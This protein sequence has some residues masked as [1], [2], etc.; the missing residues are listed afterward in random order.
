M[1]IPFIM[2]ACVMTFVACSRN[3]GTASFTLDHFVVNEIEFESLAEVQSYLLD[4]AAYFY[5]NIDN[6]NMHW[7]DAR[8]LESISTMGALASWHIAFLGSTPNHESFFA[9]NPGKYDTNN[10]RVL[11][12][13]MLQSIEM[14]LEEFQGEI[15][16]QGFGLTPVPI[17]SFTEITENEELLINQLIDQAGEEFDKM[18]VLELPEGIDNP[19][20]INT[21][22]K[23]AGFIDYFRGLSFEG[24]DFE[25]QR[26]YYHYLT[27]V[28]LDLHSLGSQL[29]VLSGHKYTIKGDTVTITNTLAAGTFGNQSYT[30]KFVRKAD[31]WVDLLNESGGV[32]VRDSFRL[33]GDTITVRLS[34]NTAFSSLLIDIVYIK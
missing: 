20:H 12:R 2:V 24:L 4:E 30:H 28:S 11:V 31:G 16:N 15:L 6:T 22:E 21:E 3:S 14:D 27:Q 25:Y 23:R 10:E 8:Y 13:Y 7:R 1:I 32:S 26:H 9:H 34:R 29:N 33:V 18:L 19:F 5:R 17:I